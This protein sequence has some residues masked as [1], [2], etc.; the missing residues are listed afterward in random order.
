MVDVAPFRLDDDVV[1][2]YLTR[3]GADRADRADLSLTT[4]QHRHVE[5]IPYE[6]LD[7]RLDREIRLD[8]DSL[9]DKLVDRR[10]G[11]YC[12]EQNT[13]FAAVLEAMGYG[14]TRCLGRVRLGDATSA[15]PETHMVMIVDGQLVD[16]G[17]GGAN[18]LGPVPI[19]GEV[20][21]G[22]WTWSTQRTRAPEGGEV[23]LVRLFDM[24]L[25]TFTEDPRH[26]IDYI[27][28][29]H[30]TS[31]YP[32]SLFRNATIVQRWDGATQIGIVGTELTVRGADSTTEV[33]RFDPSEL[34]ALLLDRF[35]LRLD[36]DDLTRLQHQLAP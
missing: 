6:N 9:V 36:R 2:R 20:T 7:V 3:I 24:P 26:P 21:Y 11:G 25:Y 14:V 27:T 22:P 16:V 17:F 23:W 12:F 1:E 34:G 33:S 29:N 13:L 10:R 15:R 5:A 30:F 19:D 4:L 28:P 32:L 18:P 35:G 31:T 8:L